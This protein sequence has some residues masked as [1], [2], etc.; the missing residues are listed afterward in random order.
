MIKVGKAEISRIEEVV[1]DEQPSLFSGWTDETLAKHR[2]LMVPNFYDP[3]AGAFRANIHSWLVK[4]GGKVI[5]IDTCGGNFKDR[6]ASPRFHQLNFPYLERLKAAGVTPADVDT[7]ICTHLHIDHVG[8]NTHLVDGKWVPTFTN[9]K[10]IFPRIEVEWRDPKRGAKEKP[11]A[12]N[13]PFID[14]VQPILDAGMATLVEGTERFGDEIDFM[15][16][17]GHAPGQMAVRLRSG[18]EEAL[19]VADISHQPIQVYY[20]DWSSKYCEDPKLATQTRRRMFEYL[21]DNKSLMLPGHYGPPHGGYIMRSGEGFELKL[22][23]ATP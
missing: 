14:S 11:P 17:P 21:A 22:P 18:G 16:T 2:D 7:V 13:L 8:W 12:V 3:K 1:L 9:A 20:P 5:L 6:P 15:P 4:L 19:F 10:Y 23:D